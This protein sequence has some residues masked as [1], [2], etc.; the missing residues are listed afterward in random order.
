VSRALKESS[1]RD[2]VVLCQKDVGFFADRKFIDWFG[3]YLTDVALVRDRVEQQNIRY[4]VNSVSML[5]A[6]SG[7]VDAYLEEIFSVQ[8]QAEDFILMERKEPGSDQ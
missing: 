8:Y 3:R 1:T 7:D 2:D 4:A 6:A 5:N